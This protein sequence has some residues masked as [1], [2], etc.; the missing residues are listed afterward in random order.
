MV[1]R[2]TPQDFGT[3]VGELGREQRNRHG[4]TCVQGL[5]SWRQGHYADS[6][7]LDQIRVDCI[8]C[9][10]SRI[11]RHGSALSL[12]QISSCLSGAYHCVICH[13]SKAT[14]TADKRLENG[15]SG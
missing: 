12:S 8:S 2:M 5:K 11:L 7:R 13:H 6:E 15:C 3:F 1:G 10:V 4:F 9:L 14:E